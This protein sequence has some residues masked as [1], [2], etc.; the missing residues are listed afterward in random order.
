MRQILLFGAQ[1]QLGWELQRTLA[2]L[3][4][5]TAVDL[6]EVD[7]SQ[8]E[9][10]R[11]KINEIKPKIL[12]NAAAYT[13][14]DKAEEQ[15]DIAQSVNC[16]APATMAEEAKKNNALFVHYSTD[17][18]FSGETSKPYVET[19]TPSP[20]GVYGRTK[21]AGDDTVQ[22]IGGDFLIFR[23]SWVYGLR[24]A[25][26]LKTMLRLAT[27]RKELSIVSDQIG[28]PT[29]SRMLAETTTLAVSKVLSMPDSSKCSGIY[30]VSGHGHTSWFEFAEKII[31]NASKKLNFQPPEIKPIPTSEYPTPAPR[32]AYSVLNNGLFEKEFQ[33]W[34]P[35]WEDQ[36][37]LCL[38]G[39]PPNFLHQ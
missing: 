33:L 12:V 19:D 37:E 1:G 8:P 35:H 11:A 13:A 21:L 5:V 36:L 15:P 25:N 28:T 10:I 30:N 9:A 24:G 27:E 23:T 31:A 7:I 29:W 32:P 18:V 4:K 16:L 39:L 26:F 14:V 38:K 34:V 17:Y 2:P 6:Q 20:L 22:E 3:G